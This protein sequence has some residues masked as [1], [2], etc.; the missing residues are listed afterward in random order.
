MK[1]IKPR[2]SLVKDFSITVKSKNELP[3][4]IQFKGMTESDLELIFGIDNT[5]RL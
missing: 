1:N 2:Q 5:E 3:Q 4:E